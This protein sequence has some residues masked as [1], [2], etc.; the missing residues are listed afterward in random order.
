MRPANIYAGSSGCESNEAPQMTN[1]ARAWIAYADGS[2]LGN[3]GRGGWGVVLIDPDGATS[4]LAGANPSTTNNRMEITAVIEALRQIPAG[5]EIALHSDS[6]YVI[7]TMT[8]GWKRRENLDLWPLLDEAAARHRVRWEWVR[9]H[10]GDPLNER[11]DELARS[12]AEGRAPRPTPAAQPSFATKIDAKNDSSVASR[13][14][15][16]L[17]PGEEIRGCENCRRAFVAVADSRFCSLAPCQL[18]ARTSK[19]S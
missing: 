18:K 15:P 11:A 4:E 17:H 2:C 14:M 8:L 10:N 1:R 6:Q 5:E 16:L 12:A 9:G 7:K 3:P 19:S 13:L